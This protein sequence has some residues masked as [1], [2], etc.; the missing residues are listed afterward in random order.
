MP[1]KKRRAKTALMAFGVMPLLTTVVSGCGAD[2][3]QAQTTAADQVEV[4]EVKV[5]NDQYAAPDLD[6]AGMSVG[7]MD[8]FSGNALRDGRKVGHGG[9][10]C[11]VIHVDGERV[12]AQCLLTMELEHGSV[13]MQALWVRGSSPL[14]MAIT[15]GTDAYRDARGTVRFWD[16][17]TP[18]ERVRAEIIR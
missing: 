16:I 3:G 9:G 7:D 11:Q 18:N 10:S 13:T 1:N 12:T 2:D 4:L 6:C 8:V 14:D 15:G 17:G 5:E